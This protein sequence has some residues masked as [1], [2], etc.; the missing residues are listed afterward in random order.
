M[1]S[2]GTIDATAL[3]N[4]EILQEDCKKKSIQMVMS[5][6]NEQPMKVMTKAGFVEKVGKEN[7]CVNIDA[8]LKRAQD[9]Q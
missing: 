9:L 2:V 1:R 7:F 4:L 8:A 3:H 6:V 5:H